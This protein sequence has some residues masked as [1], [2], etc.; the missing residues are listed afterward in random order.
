M[1]KIHRDRIRQSLQSRR[2]KE[3]KFKFFGKLCIALTLGFI[4]F[5]LLNVFNNGYRAFIHTQ[6]ELEV[7]FPS[8]DFAL[9]NPELH[10]YNIDWRMIARQAVENEAAK[11]GDESLIVDELLSDGLPWQLSEYLLQNPHF[12]DTRQSVWVRASSLLDL[13]KKYGPRHT[14]LSEKQALVVKNW[15]QEGRVRVVFNWHF[16]TSGVSRNPE[17]AGIGG[18]LKGTFL[19]LMVT[20]LVSFPVA[21]GAA[22][23]LEEFAQRNRFSDIVEVSINNLAAVPSIIFGLLGL[24]VFLEVFGMPRSAPVVGGLVLS[25]MT[26][27]TI[28]IAARSSIKAV[29]PSIRNAALALGASQTQVV[30]HH[31]LPAAMPGIL[32]GAIIGMAQALGETAPLIM[33]GMVAFIPEIPMS[34]TDP[35]AAL[36]VQIFLWSD[37]AEVGFLEKTSGA[38]LVLLMFLVS[39]NSIAVLLRR[40]LEKEYK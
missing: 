9:G 11:R 20:F 33:I 28:I 32:T 18:A 23:Y 14:P 3:R 25:L 1:T 6:V 35:S 2:S 16:L 10:T 15:R 34:L 37:A 13:H 30:F 21:I 36:P 12:G 27:P 40:R 24:A 38:I 8:A 26:M 22:I 19:M 17:D 4:I 29:S 39:M 7:D 31:V 5:M